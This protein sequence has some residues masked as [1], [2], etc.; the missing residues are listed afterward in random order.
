VNPNRNPE[1]WPVRSHVEL[2]KLLGPDDAQFLYNLFDLLDTASLGRQDQLMRAFPMEVW[3]WL[4]YRASGGK[5]LVG[6]YVRGWEASHLNGP[7]E[8]ATGA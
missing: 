4:N 5:L 3:A 2:A 7:A 1:D 8:H 6:D